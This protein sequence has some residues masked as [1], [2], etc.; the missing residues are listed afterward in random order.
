L[1]QRDYKDKV[2]FK[3]VCTYMPEMDSITAGRSAFPAPAAVHSSADSTVT[4]VPHETQDDTQL[5][6]PTN[7]GERKHRR[8]LYIIIGLFVLW[9][10]GNVTSVVWGHYTVKVSIFPL[11]EESRALNKHFTGKFFFYWLG[12]QWNTIFAGLNTVMLWVL[13]G[14][15]VTTQ[16]ATD[17][18]GVTQ[19]D[20]EATSQNDVQAVHPRLTRRAIFRLA[21]M[22]IS[23][24]LALVVVTIIFGAAAYPTWWRVPS[25]ADWQRKAWD[26]EICL[27]WDYKISFDGVDFNHLGLETAENEGQ[28]F[29]SNASIQGLSGGLI[30]MSLQHPGSNISLV[31]INNDGH[32]STIEFNFTSLN[33]SSFDSSTGSFSRGPDLA[34]PELSLKSQ[35]SDII[36]WN[37]Y[38]SAP[39]V[40][41]VDSNNT[42]VLL[43]ILSNYDDCTMM[44]ACSNGPLERLLV[45]VGFILI[46]MEKSGLCCTNPER[47]GALK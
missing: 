21:R 8:R 25:T 9:I 35:Y 20:V 13:F 24:L 1:K 17:G 33:Y 28:R 22:F 32:T 45:P 26:N 27:G 7:T 36:Q 40:S 4:L 6:P 31:S 38:C 30:E 14:P 44:T 5:I 10:V 2:P 37:P 12:G 42:E 43:T 18:Q 15:V 3:F 34:F 16:A 29:L 41:L 19:P 39:R 47:Y 23:L 11:S 46:E